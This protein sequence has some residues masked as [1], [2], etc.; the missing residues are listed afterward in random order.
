[1]SRLKWLLNKAAVENEPGLTNAQLMLTNNDLRPGKIISDGLSV[2]R[3]LLILLGCMKIE[4][5]DHVIVD[6]ER[7]Q[8][9]WRNYIAFWI[10]D[11]LNIV[12]TS[13]QYLR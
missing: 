11:S 8:W 1:M 2:S 7:R 3:L 9:K 5:N 12:S 10:A 4:A 6:P 13:G